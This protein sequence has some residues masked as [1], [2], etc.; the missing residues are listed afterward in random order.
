MGFR[1][2]EVQ[3]LSPRLK[4]LYL[5]LIPYK[6]IY[7]GLFF[8]LLSCLGETPMPGNFSHKNEMIAL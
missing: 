3:I 2:S 1:G 6:W 4:Y 5:V 7:K 8:L